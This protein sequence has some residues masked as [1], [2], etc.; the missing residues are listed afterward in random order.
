VEDR[1]SGDD[2][3]DELRE[4]PVKDVDGGEDKVVLVAALSSSVAVVTEPAQ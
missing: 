2:E 3:G 4:Y 1:A